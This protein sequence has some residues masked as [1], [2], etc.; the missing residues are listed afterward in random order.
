MW[1]IKNNSSINCLLFT[2]KERETP[3]NNK[4]KKTRNRFSIEFK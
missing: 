3:E 4:I 2:H 1:G